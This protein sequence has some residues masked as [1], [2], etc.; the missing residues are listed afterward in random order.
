MLFNSYIF[1]FAF[2]PVTLL[3]YLFLKQYHS[4]FAL[5]IL[6]IASCVFY[7]WSDYSFLSILFLS[8]T[9]NYVTAYLL[10]DITAQKM[11]RCIL[12]AGLIFNL[13][14]LGYFK[15]ADFFIENINH[16]TTLHIPALQIVLP[17]GISFFTFTQIAFIVDCYRR[18]VKKIN[19]LHYALFVTYFPHLIAGP[20]IHHQEVMP[21]FER[22]R[23]FM[24]H[25]KNIII[26]LTVFSVGLFK[27][28]VIADYFADIVVPVFD[29]QT[30]TISTFDAWVGALAY[31]FELYFDFS[32]YSDMAIGL[33]LLFGIKL[34]INF[35]SPYKAVNI[36]EFWRR[37]N[38][39][40]SRFLK[41]YLYIPLGGNQKGTARR[42]LN[43]MLTMLL[44]GLW[45]GANWTFVMWGGLH[46]AY[47]CINHGWHACKQR[48]SWLSL[49]WRITHYASCLITFVA[50]IIAWVFFRAQ[51]MAT[52][53]KI[54]QV[55]FNPHLLHVSAWMPS[56][57]RYFSLL[58]LAG[59]LFLSSFICWQLPNTAQWIA[60]YHVIIE[61]VP[62]VSVKNLFQWRPTWRWNVLTALLFVTGVSCIQ[63]SS[64][65]L[66]F[67]F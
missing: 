47:L 62:V 64:I 52:G 34:P 1:I 22:G 14:L 56:A 7:G 23:V 66:Y 13:G 29:T 24:R 37:W 54:L 26:G 4:Q 44:G 50:V 55:M 51:D 3:I 59:Y 46:G 41:E 11:R 39:T 65:F 21:Q 33:S 48:F 61:S 49:Q 19:F 32:G 20:I 17:I 27:K 9:A 40:L 60:R 28:T 42:Y 53:F 58:K 43:L 31:T 57:L 36:I 2:L 35:Y 25:Y 10:L 16:I 15:Y 67:R 18:M 6:L 38:I 5:L 30:L 12:I 8:I 45:H 63:T